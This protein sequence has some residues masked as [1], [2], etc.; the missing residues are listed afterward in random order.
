MSFGGN[1][2]GKVPFN[3]QSWNELTG[4]GG[5]EYPNSAVFIQHLWQG[6][7][8]MVLCEIDAASADE[9]SQWEARLPP[10]SAEI[11]LHRGDWRER[12]GGQL[13]DADGSL[14]SFDPYMIHGEN[15]S[16]PLE[17]C[18]Y[19]RDLIRAASITL[20]IK[21]SRLLVQL[22]TY[23]AQNSPQEQVLSIAE[24]VMAAVGLELV[25]AVRADGHMMSMVFGR[26]V[27]AHRGKLNKRFG[28]W[29]LSATKPA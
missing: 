29:L 16:A 15:A 1:S 4:A 28:T 21:S 26:D 6:P 22:S 7:V 9:I 3:E 14:L 23:S 8:R 13:P 17:G 10:G 20:N 25:D 11:E 2:L 19:L 24:W 27:P 5:S 12:L 18:M